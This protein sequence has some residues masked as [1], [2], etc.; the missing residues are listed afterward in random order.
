[1][2]NDY[3]VEVASNL[4]TNATLEPAFLPVAQAQGNIT[5]ASNQRFIRFQYGIPFEQ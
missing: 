5:D 2:A 1:M 4:Q 3:L